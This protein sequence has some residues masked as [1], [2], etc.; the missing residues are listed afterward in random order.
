MSDLYRSALSTRI[1]KLP[2]PSIF[3]DEDVDEEGEEADTIGNLPGSGI[4]PPAM[5]VEFR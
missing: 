2:P 3:P 1:A 5:Q 4:G